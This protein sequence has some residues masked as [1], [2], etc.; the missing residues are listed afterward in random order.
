[1]GPRHVGAPWEKYLKG[2]RGEGGRKRKKERKKK[3][4]EKRHRKNRE[5]IYLLRQSAICYKCTKQN[6][7]II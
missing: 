2:G 3:E 1:M 4:K 6:I 7:I 5:G